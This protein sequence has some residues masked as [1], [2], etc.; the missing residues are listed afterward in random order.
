MSKK[1]R[2]AI[3]DLYKGV[4]NQGMR[5]LFN[6]VDSFSELIDYDVFNVREKFEVPGLDYDIYI[7]SGGPGSPLHCSGNW[8][9][10]WYNWLDELWNHNQ[11]SDD[12]KKYVFLI[13][14]SF[15]MA[16]HHFGLGDL[17]MRKSKSF[18]VLPVHKTKAGKDEIILNGLPDPFYA[19]DSREWQLIQ[20]RLEVFEE[21]A[22]TILALEKIRTYVE[23]ERAIMAVRFSNEI[24]GTQFH[25][26]ADPLGMKTHFEQEEKRQY[27]ITNFGEKKYEDMMVHLDDPDKIELTHGTVI[28]S[29]IQD[30]LQHHLHEIPAY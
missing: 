5:S 26:E 9:H 20:P 18:G 11:H 19:V 10:K 1:V 8:E 3:L 14:H 2:L 7:S 17:T 12:Q 4:E 30:A 13:C 29:F 16:C 27:V 23:Y 24:V 21:H 15:Q 22:A 28:P 6:I 25:P